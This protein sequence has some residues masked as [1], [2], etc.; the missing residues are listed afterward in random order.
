MSGLNI[1]Y[2]NNFVAS[3]VQYKIVWFDSIS[4]VDYFQLLYKYKNTFFC[5]AQIQKVVFPSIPTLQQCQGDTGP[6]LFGMFQKLPICPL[7]HSFFNHGYDHHPT[8]GGFVR[9]HL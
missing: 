3:Y 4:G 7:N 6:L 2:K 5:I 1:E 8:L 9:I